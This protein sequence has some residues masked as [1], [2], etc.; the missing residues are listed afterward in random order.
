MARA[1]ST[2]LPAFGPAAIV[3]AVVVVGACS[4]KAPTPPIDPIVFGVSLGLSNALAEFAKP[5]QDAIRV[6][7]GYINAQG[8]ILGRP[9]KFQIADDKSD[10][11][12]VIGGVVD[13]FVGQKVPVLVGPLGSGQVEAVWKKTAG[14]KLTQISPSATSVTFSTLADGMDQRFFFRTVP[15]DDIQGRA[16]AKL[17]L[18]G[19]PSGGDAGAGTPCKRMAI[20][21]NSDAY[22]RTMAP[23]IKDSFTKGGGTVALT[24]EVPVVETPDYAPQVEEI[25]KLSPPAECVAFVMYDDV[26]GAFLVAYRKRQ[27]STPGSNPLPDF[28]IGTDGSYTSGLYKN[29][30]TRGGDGSDQIAAA[31][32]YGTNPDT[33]PEGSTEYVQFRNIYLA[34]YTLPA[35]KTEPEPFTANTFDAAILAALAVEAAGTTEDPIR[36][37]DAL[38]D[39][40]NPSS[41]ST[42]DK[43][44]RPADLG[45]GLLAIRAGEHVDY[46]GASGRVDLNP[47]TG[48]VESGYIF[49]QATK[50][51]FVTVRR[52]AASE[53]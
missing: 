21:H 27:G 22:G 26:A 42:P 36:I 48:N 33:N 50:S 47:Q 19:P 35:N 12:A 4:S 37:R 10:T 25:A 49:W 29:S 53:L 20:V 9:V 30:T 14:A 39:V 40:A 31:G 24:V 52:V 16:V 41:G 5:Q 7:E 8:G 44:I 15:P 43:L 18:S 1:R 34:R 3:V 23:V 46:S 32:V 11:G 45:E 51:G 17:A 13:G 6:A 28:L 2:L 38:L